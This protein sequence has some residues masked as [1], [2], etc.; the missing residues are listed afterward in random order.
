MLSRFHLIPERYGRTDGQTDRPTDRFAISISRVSMLT[1]DKNAPT[2]A[3]CNFNKHRLIL[4]I[5]A[6]RCYASAVLA[7]MRCPSLCVSVTFLDSV[8][9]TN[10]ILIRFS[11]WGS[12][13]IL[14]SKPYGN[15]PTGIPL[16]ATGASNAGGGG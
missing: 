16:T 5:F 9:T 15:I 1:R 14:R 8:K 3:S 12:Q 4:I 6:A 10:R 7:V 13:T 11:P 2:L